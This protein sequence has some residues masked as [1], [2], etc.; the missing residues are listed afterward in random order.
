M[1]LDVYLLQN[2]LA[3]SRTQARDLIENGFVFLDRG[4]KSIC[5]QKPGYT[6]D[7]SE[8]G[9][10]RVEENPLQKYVS[11]AGLK[12]EGALRHTRCEAKGKTVLDVGQSTGGFTD[13]ILRAGARQVVGVDVGHGQIHPDLKE[14]PR[15]TALEGLHAK[16][17]AQ[18][19]LFQKQVPA[20]GFDLVLADVSFISLEKVMPFLAPFLKRDGEYLFLVKPQF[21]CGAEHLDK[22]GIVRDADVYVEVEKRIRQTAGQIF[23]E[24]IG[25]FRSETPGKDGNQE[26]FIYGKKNT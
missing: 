21:E 1:R 9:S 13:C 26:F 19:E 6:V 4:G 3:T 2:K 11:R 20:G 14:N 22:N 23:G 18:S 16:D 5:L 15:V 24:V 7:E 17:I 8:R 10:I 12:L 25:Y